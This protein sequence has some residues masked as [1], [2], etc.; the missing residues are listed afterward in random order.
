M[1]NETQSFAPEEFLARLARGEISRPIVFTGMVKRSEDDSACL[2]FARGNCTNWIKIPLSSIEQIEVLD[3]V[4]CKDHTH[5]LVKL[6]LKRPQTDEGILF[7]SL[8]QLASSSGSGDGPASL[9]RHRV[10]R[11]GRGNRGTS[12]SVTRADPG[13]NDV[14]IDDAGVWC[15]VESSEHFCIYQ[16]C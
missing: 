13:C 11:R 8:T 4:P 12:G 6:R 10:I 9:V 2:L 5:P 15:F 3:I 1:A 14:E 16:L 7:S